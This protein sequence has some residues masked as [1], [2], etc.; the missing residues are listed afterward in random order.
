MRIDSV[1]N[2]MN[3]GM[4]TRMAQGM[5]AASRN[6]QNQ[7]Q[8]KQQVQKKSQNGQSTG[9][10]EASMTALISADSSMKIRKILM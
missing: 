3:I 6:I 5:D 1:N 2:N 10:S 4:Q 8:A 9:F 7:I